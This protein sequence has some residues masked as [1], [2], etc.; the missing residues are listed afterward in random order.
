MADEALRHELQELLVANGKRE[1]E[2][3]AVGACSDQILAQL[4]SQAF[5]DCLVEH[6][7][8]AEEF[9]LAVERQK[10]S[11]QEAMLAQVNRSKLAVPGLGARP[12]G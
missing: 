8:V 10:A 6:F 7:D 2:L 5:I 4:R 1:E 9:A 12:H 3:H 11:A